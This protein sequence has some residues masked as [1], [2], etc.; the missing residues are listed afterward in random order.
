MKERRDVSAGSDGRTVRQ[1]ACAPARTRAIPVR[2]PGAIQSGIRTDPNSTRVR[3]RVRGCRGAPRSRRRAGQPPA[4]VPVLASPGRHGGCTSIPA[5]TGAQCLGRWRRSGPSQTGRLD[6]P[7]RME[8]AHPRHS[9]TAER[10]SV[11]TSRHP[12]VWTFAGRFERARRLRAHRPGGRLRAHPSCARS[13]GQLRAGCTGCLRARP[14]PE[15]PDVH[16]ATSPSRTLPSPE[17]FTDG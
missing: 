1:E 2:R 4:A 17:A 16:G 8:S 7:E 12:N 13:A 3:A 14:R 10:L 5:T 9:L 11:G 6:A 15:R